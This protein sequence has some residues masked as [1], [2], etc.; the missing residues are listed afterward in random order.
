MGQKTPYILPPL[1]PLSD[2]IETIP[3]L[4]KAAKA[5]FAIAELKG[6]A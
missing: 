6:I 2:Q 4:K 5:T 3:I 1:P